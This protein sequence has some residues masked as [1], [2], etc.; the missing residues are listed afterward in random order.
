MS[1]KVASQPVIG[2]L[3]KLLGQHM[4]LPPPPRS[5]CLRFANSDSCL[6]LMFIALLP[7]CITCNCLVDAIY[8]CTW[9]WGILRKCHW[10]VSTWS[11]LCSAPSAAT[12]MWRRCLVVSC[13]S[14]M[15][16]RGSAPHWCS[17]V[18]S[19]PDLPIKICWRSLWCRIDH[20]RLLQLPGPCIGRCL[21]IF[22]L[23]NLP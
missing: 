16:G 21:T 14:A 11:R 15:L 7:L 22:L 17:A 12:N 6:R 20:D 5:L 2:G 13:C 19:T 10:L 1:T 18:D 4:P 23:S 8:C 3:I 9:Q